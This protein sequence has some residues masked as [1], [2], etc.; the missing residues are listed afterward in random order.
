MKTTLIRIVVATA[1]VGFANLA[2]AQPYPATSGPALSPPTAY[3][4]AS[5]W[6]EGVM[7]GRGDVLRAW[8]E[9]NYNNSLA[10]LNSQEAYS[11]YLDNRLKAISTYFDMREL[12]RQYR[13]EE[14][15]QRPSEEDL[16]RYAKERAP[17]RLAAHQMDA[18]YNRLI[19]PEALRDA[20]FDAEREAVDELMMH[21]GAGSENR[22][23][24]QLTTAMIESLRTQV[25]A[26][27]PNDYVVARRFL[28][29]LHYEMNFAPGSTPIAAR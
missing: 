27:K 26:M 14:R 9:A 23:I 18:A 17:D 13:A 29:S 19:W 4:H 10:L 6:E 25:H 15:G 21:R 28:T 1:V 24:Q 5:T 8:G 7:R 2:L 11:R 22:E 16:A 20:R 12:N 3:H